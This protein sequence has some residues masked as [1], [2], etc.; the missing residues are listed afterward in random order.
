MK[1]G[2]NF[3]RLFIDVEIG[4]IL[5]EVVYFKNEKGFLIEQELEYEWKLISCKNC[6]KFDYGENV[7]RR[8]IKFVFVQII[9]EDIFV[10]D[11]EG[12]KEEF[13][14]VIYRKEMI[15]GVFRIMSF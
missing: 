3:V 14:Q 9:I 4:Y 10:F 12:D 2:I 1:V 7:C 13:L 6:F 11:E 15:K 5:I 8:Q